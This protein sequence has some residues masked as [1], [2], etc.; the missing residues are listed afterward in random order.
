MCGSW[1]AKFVSEYGIVV[2][3]NK[4]GQVPGEYDVSRCKTWGYSGVPQQYLTAAKKNPVK[5]V[6]LITTPEDAVD[7]LA[8]LH[9]IAICGSKG[10]TMKRQ[11]GGYCPVSGTWNHCQMIRGVL[12]VAGGSSSPFGGDGAFPYAGNTQALPYNNSWGD[13]LGSDNNQVR[14]IDGSEVTLPEGCY[15]STLEETKSEFAQEDSFALSGFV[16]F[17]AQEIPASIFNIIGQ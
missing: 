14:L 2:Y 3:G 11:K 13:Y 8:N 5:T 9:P 12:C 7:A 6:S 15:L 10:R 17:P 4:D 16:G 1:A